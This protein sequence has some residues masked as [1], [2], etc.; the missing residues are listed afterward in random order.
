MA[1]NDPPF[2]VVGKVLRPHGVR[3]ELRLQVLT[4][5]PER[6]KHLATALLVRDVDAPDDAQR[7][8]VERARLHQEFAILKLEGIEDRESAE[9][10][11]NYLLAVPLDEAVPLEPEEFYVF[12]LIG[13]EMV[14]DADL[15]LGTVTDILETGA[16]DVYVVHSERY[17]EL[18]IPAIEPVI[19]K[20]DLE[21]RRIIITP[22]P[23]LLPDIA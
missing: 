10:L 4:S 9:T 2:L 6:L 21:N 14:T 1:Q 22:L 17:G 7:Y 11:R 16:N 18:L 8:P 5:Y 20:I 19:Q 12:Q 23:G 13:L 3:G 15:V